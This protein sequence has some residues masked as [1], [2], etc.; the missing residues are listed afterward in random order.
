M[1][2][3]AY[4]KLQ[5]G[6]AVVGKPVRVQWGGGE[7][8]VGRVTEFNEDDGKHKVVYTDGDVKWHDLD[9][10]K[11]SE[12]SEAEPKPRQVQRGEL[13]SLTVS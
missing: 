5:R 8:Y 6:R 9:Q 10:K 13:S 12:V 7:S 1:E 3:A 2:A 11:W 4:A